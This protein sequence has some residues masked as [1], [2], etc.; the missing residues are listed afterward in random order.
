MQRY[1][2]RTGSCRDISVGLDQAE[3]ASDWIRQ[4]YQRRTGLGRDISV[5]LDQ[6]EISA[7]DWITHPEG[8]YR[9][10]C[11]CDLEISKRR[12]PELTRGVEP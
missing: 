2:R 6:A 9:A 11:V 12:R 1:Q 5:G 4:R 7:S 10:W 3:I 8:S